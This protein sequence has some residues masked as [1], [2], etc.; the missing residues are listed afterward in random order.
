M[1]LINCQ[2]KEKKTFPEFSIVNSSTTNSSTKVCFLK[3]KGGDANLESQTS[4]SEAPATRRIPQP[5]G[6]AVT[7][8]AA[9]VT[10]LAAAAVTSWRKKEDGGRSEEP[11]RSRR[12]TGEG[13]NS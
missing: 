11:N 9:A 5:F 2:K 13:R 1:H 3:V 8:L 6:A 7:S 4:S 10:S 12:R